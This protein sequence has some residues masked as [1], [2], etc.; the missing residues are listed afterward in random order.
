MIPNPLS[1][2]AEV[3]YYLAQPASVS[4]SLYSQLGERILQPMESSFM[5]SGQHS[6]ELNTSCL[7]SGVYY[8]ILYAGDGAF[9]RK[10]SIVK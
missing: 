9:S 3:V 1:E 4:L 7:A 5:S 8:L 2:N 6:I 10:V